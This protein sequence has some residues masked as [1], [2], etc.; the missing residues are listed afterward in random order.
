MS[1]PEGEAVEQSAADQ[2]DRL[3]IDDML[4]FCY[5]VL[6]SFSKEH[7]SSNNHNKTLPNWHKCI[8]IFKWDFCQ[9]FT[10]CCS[11]LSGPSN[12]LRTRTNFTS[13]VWSLASCAMALPSCCD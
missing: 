10:A 9:L 4:F 11:Q 3:N 5:V 13:S 6:S 8:R 12:G 2:L 1:V 7:E